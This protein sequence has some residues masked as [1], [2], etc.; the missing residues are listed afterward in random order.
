MAQDFVGTNNINLLQPKGQYGTRS[1]GRKHSAKS[2]YV[3]TGLS[4]MTEKVF[5]KEDEVHLNYLKQNGN[6]VEPEWYVPIVPMILIN[7]CSGVGTG[8]KTSVPMYNPLDVAN[9]MRQLIN[10][11][12]LEKMWSPLVPWYRGFKGTIDRAERDDL[13]ISSGVIQKVDNTFRITELPIGYT[14]AGYKKIL[15]S[16][17]NNK[18]KV[19]ANKPGDIIIEKIS[20][21]G[22]AKNV[23]ITVTLTEENMQKTDG[24]DP[25]ILFKL[26]TNI[27][28]NNMHLYNSDG[29]FTYYATPLKIAQEFYKVRFSHYEK[30]KEAI[31]KRLMMQIKQQ[32]NKIKFIN[33]FQSGE[34]ILTGKKNEDQMLEFLKENGI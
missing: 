17:L 16:M 22:D 11:P 3:S 28:T 12:F 9:V 32:E 26:T 14:I 25:L 31:V 6:E 29:K 30:R 2:R 19:D 20:V 34:Y 8:W 27:W 7:G 21:D 1:K 5:P 10:D 13:F 33:G 23:D 18:D 4:D 15:Q 24:H